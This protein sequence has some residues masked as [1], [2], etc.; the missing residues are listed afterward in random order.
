MSNDVYQ[1]LMEL[2]KKRGFFWGS[3]EIY[4]GLSGFYDM[5]PLGVLVK[6]ELIN[7]WLRRFVYSNDLVVEI[8]TPLINPRIVFQASGH[9]ESFLDPVLVCESCG[10]VY[11][12]DHLIKERLGLDVEGWSL[13]QLEQVVRSNNLN[14]PECG[15]RLGKPFNVM[16]LFK[17]EIGP[18]RGEPGY[19]KPEHAQGMFINFANVLR[20]RRN[21]L[22]FGVAQVGRVARNEISPRQGLLRLREFTIMELEFFFDPATAEEEFKEYIQEVI[23][24]ELRI[25]TADM[26]INHVDKPKVFAV[27]ELLEK[28]IVKTPWM[29]Y[30]MAIGNRF[31]KELGIADDNIRFVEKLPHERAHYSAQTFDQEVYTKK[32]GWVEVAG[33]AYRTDFDLKRHIDYSKADLYY[34]K[35]YDEPVERDVKKAVPDYSKI[36]SALGDASQ[37]VLKVLGGVSQEELYAQ[38]E[39]RGFVEVAGVRLGPE[40]FIV[41]VEREKVTGKRIIPHVVEPSFGVER[42][43]YVLLEHAYTTKENRVILKLPKKLAPY[44]VAVFPLVAGK[45]PEHAKIVNLS[46]KIYRE[47]INRGYRVVY[48]DDGSIGRRYARVD[49]IGVPLAVTVD[50]QSIEDSSVTVRFRDTWEQ[51]R[52]SEKDLYEY[53]RKF[54]ED[55]PY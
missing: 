41:K 13:D 32:Y 8:E 43:L 14:C 6:R 49:E 7:V 50:Y 17:T 52:I 9:E 21:K 20:I 39:A 12:A 29:A 28:K 40:Y 26:K 45:K 34:F 18:Y 47:L 36:K 19:L 23:D 24:D 33:Y 11:R 37:E 31:L 2:A 16:L 44:H 30:W 54:F 4:G 46:K 48:D 42:V 38:L 15:G 55:E 1:E 25:I 22:P 53:I 5:G 10:R 27:R 35:K 3:Y 51:V